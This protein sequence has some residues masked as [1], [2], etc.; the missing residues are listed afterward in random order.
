MHQS[1]LLVLWLEKGNLE[2]FRNEDGVQFYDRPNT[3]LIDSA[4]LESG[5]EIDDDFKKVAGP[6]AFDSGRGAATCLSG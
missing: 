1:H 3:L 4:K 5:E 6:R 2:I